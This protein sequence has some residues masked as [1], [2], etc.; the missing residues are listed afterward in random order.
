MKDLKMVTINYSG[1]ETIYIRFKPVAAEIRDYREYLDALFEIIAQAKQK[2]AL[3][4]DGTRSPYMSREARIFISRYL[5]INKDLYTEKVIG[6]AAVAGSII[7]LAVV[8]A[9]VLILEKELRPVV[10]ATRTE[11]LEWTDRQLQIQAA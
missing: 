2:V 10:F 4:M 3:I 11:A 7:S 6:T 5:Q 1:P 9:L 8:K